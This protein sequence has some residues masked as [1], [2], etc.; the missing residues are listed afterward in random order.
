ME[1]TAAKLT[2]KERYLSVTMLSAADN[3]RYSKLNEEL[4]NDYTK[5][6]NHYPKTVTDAYNLIMN[7]RQTSTSGRV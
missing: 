5:G 6:R 2:A 7:Y 3:S 1:I 4:E